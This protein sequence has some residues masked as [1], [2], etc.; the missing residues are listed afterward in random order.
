[1]SDT[2]RILV[3]P[4]NW[5][6][7]HA[8]RCIPII[9]ALLERGFEVGLASDGVAL[10]LLRKEFPRLK[11]HELPSYDI[12]YA[13]KGSLFKL[14]MIMDSPKVLKAIAGERRVIADIITEGSY[15]GLISD[16]RLGCFNPDVP[17]VFIS[18]Q[19]NV[20][21][22]ST[23][24]F[25]SW[26]HQRI[27]AQFRECWVPDFEGKTNLTGRLGHVN[28]RRLNLKYMG[29]LSRFE[30][31][32][33]PIVYDLMVLLSGPEPQ[34]SL[35]EERLL[36]ELRSYQG[37]VLFVS[38]VIEEQQR[39]TPLELKSGTGTR[40]N[41]MTSNQLEGALNQ[42]ARVLCRSGYTTVMDLAKLGKTAFFIPTPGQYEQ[43]YLAE[44]LQEQ[45]WVPFC[46][47][48]DFAL[49]QLERIPEFKGLASFQAEVPYTSLF[50]AFSS[51][52][53]NSDPTS[54]SLST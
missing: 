40:Y 6:L 42:S 43:V 23:T 28:H 39:T 25:S 18:H 36:R 17:S 22:G 35:L 7:G 44:R 34:R 27:I 26:W 51:V 32:E 49:S 2:K 1:M 46:R 31:R 19:L 20:L 37:R 3:A 13:S 52:K 16:N 33:E 45:R 53:E 50:T 38:G 21:S 14:K 24:W 10:A 5:G 4:L 29:P 41:F 15:D 54:S 11:A 47:Q 8:T 12:T 9:N 30:P 48:E